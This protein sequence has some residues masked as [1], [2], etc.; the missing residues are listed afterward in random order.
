MP[1]HFH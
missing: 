1:Q